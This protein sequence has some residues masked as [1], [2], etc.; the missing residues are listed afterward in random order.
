MVRPGFHRTGKSNRYKLFRVVLPAQRRI[1]SRQSDEILRCAQN[2]KGL[3]DGCITTAGLNMLSC[4]FNKA[5][6]GKRPIGQGGSGHSCSER[7]AGTRVSCALVFMTITIHPRHDFR[8]CSTFCSHRHCAA[9][10]LRCSTGIQIVAHEVFR[11]DTLM[12]THFVFRHARTNTLLIENVPPKP[13]HFSLSFISRRCAGFWLASA[14]AGFSRPVRAGRSNYRGSDCVGASARHGFNLEDIDQTHLKRLYHFAASDLNA[15]SSGSPLF[16]QVRSRVF[17]FAWSTSLKARRQ[18]QSRI[19]PA[20]AVPMFS[21]PSR[22]AR[23]VAGAGRSRFA[24]R[25]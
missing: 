3:A 5:C 10:A 2:E 22:R 15:V 18:M 19:R 20:P 9:S 23:V 6:N 7:R 24:W 17:S 16:E 14:R 8:L 13:Q 1:S 11:A 12:F 4:R 25:E 21:K